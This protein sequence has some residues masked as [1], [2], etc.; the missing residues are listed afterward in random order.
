MDGLQNRSLPI[1]NTKLIP[2]F[3][4]VHVSVA[5]K[6][7]AVLNPITSYMRA[8]LCPEEATGGLSYHHCIYI[9]MLGYEQM[10]GENL[11]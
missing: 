8:L 5:H 1:K 4:I 6:M 3:F 10:Y 11:L 9:H 7:V 2:D